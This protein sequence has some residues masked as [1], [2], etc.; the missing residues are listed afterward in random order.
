VYDF[1]V[2]VDEIERLVHH[3]FMVSHQQSD[4]SP[5][6]PRSTPSIFHEL[7]IG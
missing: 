6:F 4:S 7:R 1:R 5:R 3:G 2:G